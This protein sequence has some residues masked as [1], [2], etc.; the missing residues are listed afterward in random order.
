M[1]GYVQASLPD[2]Q[3]GTRNNIPMAYELRVRYKVVSV[4]AYRWK[5]QLI[6]FVPIDGKRFGKGLIGCAIK[7][8]CYLYPVTEKRHSCRYFQH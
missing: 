5:D 7:R 8:F 6:G 3:Q 1:F 2:Q 4:P